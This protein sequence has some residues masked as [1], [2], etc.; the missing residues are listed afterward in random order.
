M[1]SCFSLVDTIDPSSAAPVGALQQLLVLA[2]LGLVV[3]RGLTDARHQKRLGLRCDVACRSS[4]C[5]PSGI[6]IASAS[7]TTAP[8]DATPRQLPVGERDQPGQ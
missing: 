1:S 8:C 5:R 2:K 7:L 4:E 6:V 3:A